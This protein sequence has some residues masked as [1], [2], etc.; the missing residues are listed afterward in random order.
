MFNWINQSTV[1]SVNLEVTEKLLFL[2]PDPVMDFILLLAKYYIYLIKLRETTVLSVQGSS[3]LL[4]RIM[5]QKYIKVTVRI[6]MKQMN[7]GKNTNL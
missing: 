7:V 6:C 4:N 5:P 1:T 2:S 3:I